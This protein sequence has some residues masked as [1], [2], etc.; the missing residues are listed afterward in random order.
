MAGPVAVDAEGTV[1]VGTAL[2]EE[3]HSSAAVGL[4]SAACSAAVVGAAAVVC[5]GE[6]SVGVPVQEAG[7]SVGHQVANSLPCLHE[8]QYMYIH[9]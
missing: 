9:R 8:Y 5:I 3:L 1:A 7:T 2:V 6:V 4:P